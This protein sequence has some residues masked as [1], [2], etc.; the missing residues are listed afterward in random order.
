MRVMAGV[1]VST[2][3]DYTGGDCVRPLPALGSSCAHMRHADESTAGPGAARTP[4]T[5]MTGGGG[6]SQAC[7]EIGP[8]P[9]GEYSTINRTVG[10]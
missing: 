1:R 3:F 4:G 5:G 7:G 6:T 2:G 8:Q 9:R 10:Q